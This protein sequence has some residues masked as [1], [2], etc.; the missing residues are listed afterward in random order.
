MTTHAWHPHGMRT[1]STSPPT[2]ARWSMLALLLPVPAWKSIRCW[3][4]G[5]AC[6][7]FFTQRHFCCCSRRT[8]K[9]SVLLF[10]HVVYMSQTWHRSWPDTASSLG[11][12][13]TSH[14]AFACCT[15]TAPST[16]YSH[17]MSATIAMST[18]SPPL[19]LWSEVLFHLWSN[20]VPSSQ[21]CCFGLKLHVLISA[22]VEIWFV[23]SSN[24][25]LDVMQ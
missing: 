17:Y 18:S 16:T 11:L 1:R 6:R 13:Y 23:F 15:R 4:R 12:T 8:L 5:C 3:C 25:M 9:F 10:K 20:L 2:N 7:R 22:V 14:G 21:F 19:P 24:L